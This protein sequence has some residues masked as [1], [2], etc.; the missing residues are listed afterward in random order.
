[1]AVITIHV[2]DVNY[3]I[4]YDALRDALGACREIVQQELDDGN[5]DDEDYCR[6]K[7]TAIDNILEDI[8][9]NA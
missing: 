4:A 8:N 1:M 6:H 7:L 9:A 5:C 3:N 2:D